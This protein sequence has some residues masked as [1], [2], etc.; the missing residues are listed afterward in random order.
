MASAAISAFF[1]NV[2]AQQIHAF[3]RRCHQLYP[4]H[5]RRTKNSQV[6]MNN[7]PLLTIAD[8]IHDGIHDGVSN[9]VINVMGDKNDMKQRLDR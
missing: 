2:T 9:N 3:E 8:S 6:V 4:H 5:K 1:S 7:D